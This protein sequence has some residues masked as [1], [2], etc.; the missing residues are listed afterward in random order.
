MAVVVILHDRV[1]RVED[2]R[3]GHA[4]DADV[5]L[6]VAANGFHRLTSPVSPT[7]PGARRLARLHQLL[8]APQVFAD[9]LRR[10][11]AEQECDEAPGPAGGCR[12]TAGSR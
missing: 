11:L 10:R 2:L 9:G 4:L 8:E 3:I 12:R 5:F 1:A 7:M 6:A